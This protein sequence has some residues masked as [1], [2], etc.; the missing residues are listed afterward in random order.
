MYTYKRQPDCGLKLKAI[1]IGREIDI[2]SARAVIW[3]SNRGKSYKMEGLNFKTMRS[4]YLNCFK[5][6]KNSARHIAYS[7]QK[8]VSLI[9]IIN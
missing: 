6:R 8:N 1:S 7:K 2:E 9:N 4:T 5:L 3:S